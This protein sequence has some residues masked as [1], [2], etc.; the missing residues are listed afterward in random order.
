MPQT[1][2]ET[3]ILTENSKN[4]TKGEEHKKTWDA[5]GKNIKLLETINFK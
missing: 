3:T 4:N 5:L 2:N 1:N